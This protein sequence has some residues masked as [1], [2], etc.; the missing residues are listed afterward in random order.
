MF[1]GLTHQHAVK[2]I[3][4]HRGQR[5]KVTDTGFIEGQARYLMLDT[6]GW[7]DRSLVDAVT[8]VC[9]GQCLIIASQ[10]ETTL[11]IDFIP[12]VTHTVTPASRQPG[13]PT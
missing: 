4:V 9:P 12:W 11:K 7:E 3:A 10:R 8:A 2:R 1:D 13:I 5:G 6:L